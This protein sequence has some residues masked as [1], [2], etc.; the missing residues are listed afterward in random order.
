MAR[1]SGGKLKRSTVA[2]INT[3]ALA[4]NLES[5]R[6]WF[7]GAAVMAMVKANA[8]GHGI[9]GVS[10]VLEHVGVEMFGVAFVAEGVLLRKAGIA[11]PIMVLTPVEDSDVSDAVE[12]S[13]TV[14]VSTEQE[15]E[16]LERELRNAPAN[17]PT[18]NIHVYVDTGMHRDGVLPSKATSLVS[19]ILCNMILNIDGVLT[20]LATADD[21]NENFLN[22]QLSRFDVVMKDLEQLGVHP[23]YVHTNNTGA[24]AKRKNPDSTLVRTGL[25]L[26]GYSPGVEQVE[27][28]TQVLTL[29]SVV[30]AIRRVRAGESVSYGQRY[31]AQ[32]DTTIV[33]IP[34]GYGDGYSRALTGKA[35]CMIDGKIYPV[36]GT[37]CMD[38]VMVDVGNDDVKVGTVVELINTTITAATIASALGTIPYEVTTGISARVPRRFEGQFAFIAETEDNV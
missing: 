14:S 30:L 34:I 8:Y 13:L 7:P 23:R 15:I 2:R 11:K 28:I 3:T 18:R 25:S 4:T 24:L 19:R 36:V 21:S 37:I 26:Y 12:H 9:V 1:R 32:S 35:C 16:S 27:G 17:H 31:V 38:E 5:I 6:K 20:H 10:R 29:E 33:T 22:E